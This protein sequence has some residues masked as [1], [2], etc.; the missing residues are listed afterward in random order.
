MKKICPDCGQERDAEQDFIWKYKD[1]GIRN[2]RCK[3]C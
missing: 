2:T 3:F 1:R